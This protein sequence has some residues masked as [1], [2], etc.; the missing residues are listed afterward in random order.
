MC[1]APLGVVVG[2]GAQVVCSLEAEHVCT[3]LVTSGV[4][5]QQL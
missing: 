3:R 2:E 4:R 5:F 1:L